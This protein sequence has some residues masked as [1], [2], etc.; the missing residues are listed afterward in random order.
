MRIASP[1]IVGVTAG[2]VLVAGL[3]VAGL[4]RA[5]MATVIDEQTAIEAFRAG[6]SAAPATA[7]LSGPSAAPQVTATPVGA[8]TPDPS[9]LARPARP[10]LAAAPAPRRTASSQVRPTPTS[11]GRT[12]AQRRQVT[13][14]V[15][16]YATEG[17]EQ[18]DALGGAQHDYPA[19]TTV[20]YTRSGCGTT[21]R[22]QPLQERV[23]ESLECAGA[24]GS[25]LRGSFQQREFFGR[26]QAERYICDP[27]APLLPRD[28]QPG[29]T[30]RGSCRSDDS[31]LA[32]TTTV[33]ALESLDVGGTAVPVV[34]LRVAGTLTGST[35]GRS[36]RELWL[37]RADGLL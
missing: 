13:P 2:A 11:A 27:G 6:Q 7:S 36:D 31:M 33:I 20:T 19:T 1:L 4:Q 22:W 17:S 21:E 12:S 30:T 23:G 18:V 34:H 10:D 9:P 35:R 37:A 26:S 28:P 32:L 5:D 15:Y 16:S 3:A 24:G 8:P 14:G 25:E 29:R